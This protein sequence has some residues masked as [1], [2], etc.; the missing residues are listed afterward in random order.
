MDHHVCFSFSRF[1]KLFGECVLTIWG[2]KQLL[3]ELED[4]RKTAYDSENEEHERKLLQLWNLLMP[5]R[6]LDSR[7][8]NAWQDLG[9][10]GTDP[11][12]DFRGMGLLGLENLL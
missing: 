4:L 2:F 7:F 1:G 6:A 12:T 11:K 8:S 5:N 9:F 3:H 10:Q